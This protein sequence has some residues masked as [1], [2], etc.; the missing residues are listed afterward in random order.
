M[1]LVDNKCEKHSLAIVGSLRKN[2]PEIPPSIKRASAK[3]TCQFPYHDNKTLMSYKLEND[4]M[5]LLHSDN[6]INK[7]E[8]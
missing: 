7:V 2:K 5:V 1:S 6:E 8:S 3:R 4:K